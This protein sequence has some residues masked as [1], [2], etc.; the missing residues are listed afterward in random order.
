MSQALT[1]KAMRMLMPSSV[2]VV[3]PINGEP[4]ASSPPAVKTERLSGNCSV[5]WRA[6]RTLY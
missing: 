1:D 2:Q 6:K 5:L 4:G 3:K